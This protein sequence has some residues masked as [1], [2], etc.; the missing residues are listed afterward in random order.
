MM[1]ELD[2]RFV[3]MFDD[4]NFFVLMLD[5]VNFLPRLEKFDWPCEHFDIFRH[6]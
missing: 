6:R 2:Q 5:D 3:L 4:V 1:S